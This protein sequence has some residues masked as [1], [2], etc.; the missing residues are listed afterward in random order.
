[1]NEL[2]LRLLY[3]LEAIGKVHEEITDTESRE[4]MRRAV[5][6]SFL[7]PDPSFVI[8]TD[9]GLYDDADNEVVKEAIKRYVQDANTIANELGMSFHA[10]L[11]AF[12]NPSVV[13]AEGA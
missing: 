10:R 9:L 6:H 4:A 11:K 2:L 13:T 8:P 1:M 3:E 7:K 5:F 12:Q